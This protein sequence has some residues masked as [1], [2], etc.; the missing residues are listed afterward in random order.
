MLV[1]VGEEC[2]H[3]TAVHE[4]DGSIGKV[5][6]AGTFDESRHSATGIHRIED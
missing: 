6:V 2:W 1:T 3:T 4:H 5:V